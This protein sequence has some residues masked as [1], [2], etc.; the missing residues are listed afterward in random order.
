MDCS[1]TC[2]RARKRTVALAIG[3]SDPLLIAELVHLKIKAALCGAGPGSRDG[4]R[5]G[6]SR[7]AVLAH[8][9]TRPASCSAQLDQ[10]SL[11]MTSAPQPSSEFDKAAKAAYGRPTRPAAQRRRRKALSEQGGS[12]TRVQR[13]RSMRAIATK[14]ARCAKAKRLDTAP[15]GTS[16]L[17]S[18]FSAAHWSPKALPVCHPNRRPDVAAR[19]GQNG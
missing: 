5:C 7:R 10:L 19:L 3:L 17:T 13:P 2:R 16:W 11:G 8:P 9:N 6:R 12:A 4:P 15:P 1:Q 14:T 18:A